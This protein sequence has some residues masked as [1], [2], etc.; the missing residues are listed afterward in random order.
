MRA[1]PWAWQHG[2]YMPP[3]MHAAYRQW[4]CVE[5]M[6]KGLSIRE[7]P[8]FLRHRNFAPSSGDGAPPMFALI[9]KILEALRVVPQAD[10]GVAHN[11]ME[12][13]EALA[14]L[15]PRAALEL[16]QAACAFLNVV[17]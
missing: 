1:A 8:L 11:L 3:R 14:G 7:N 13:A 9:A 6:N 5:C 4:L 12:R 2:W 15:D 17:R 16:R 10:D